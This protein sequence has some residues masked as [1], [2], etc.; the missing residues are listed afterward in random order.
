MRDVS[1]LF[2]MRSSVSTLLYAGLGR[3]FSALTTSLT[4]A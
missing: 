2:Q 4:D 3:S 1:L